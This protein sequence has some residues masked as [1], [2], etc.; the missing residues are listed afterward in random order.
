MSIVSKFKRVLTTL[1][2]ISMIFTSSFGNLTTKS[3]NE[4]INSTNKYIDN[5]TNN[6]NFINKYIQPNIKY[7]P[8]QGFKV[9]ASNAFNTIKDSN[10]LELAKDIAN[11]LYDSS[12]NCVS[13]PFNCASDI[14]KDIA[15]TTDNYITNI[16]SNILLKDIDTISRRA[17][18][19]FVMQILQVKHI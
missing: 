17:S 13:S 8:A 14:L 4:S 15:Y 5:S 3:L 9:Q 1:L 16:G 11:G 18:I 2:S 19:L 10:K 12:I 7:T 6:L